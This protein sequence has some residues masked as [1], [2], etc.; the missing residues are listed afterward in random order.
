VPNFFIALILA[1]MLLLGS[2]DPDCAFFILSFNAVINISNRT[3][4]KKRQ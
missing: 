3:M 1:E 2:G 4:L